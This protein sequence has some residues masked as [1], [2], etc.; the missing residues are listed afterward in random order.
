MPNKLPL[1]TKALFGLGAA[2]AGVKENA[3]GVF[4]IFFYA[5]VVGLSA[6]LAGLAV[7]CALV[8]DAIS[9]PLVGYWSD[10][11]KSKWGRRHPFIYASAIP[12]AFSF[13][14]LFSPPEG[15]SETTTF[16]WMLVFSIAVRFSITFNSIPAVSLVAELAT[17]YSDRNGL[18]SFRI[19]FGWTGSIG[20]SY[21]AYKWL[22]NIME[23]GQ[24]GRFDLGAY[25]TYGLIGALCM[26]ITV[27]VSG[28]GTHHLIPTLQ[29]VKKSNLSLKTFAKAVKFLATSKTFMSLLGAVLI[30]SVSAGVLDVFALYVNTYFWGLSSEQLVTLLSG[31]IVGALIAF[32]GIKIYGAKHD[33]KH[34]LMF[35]IMVAIITGP[36]PI[37]L[38]LLGLLPDNGDP[39]ILYIVIAS[40]LFT[41]FVNVGV[42]IL[43]N[44]MVA[45]IADVHYV[46]S[47]VRQEGLHYSAVTFCAKATTGLG[48]F[49]AGVSLDIISFPT[50]VG[51]NEV[52]APVIEALG[53]ANV[54]LVI[55]FLFTS[56]FMLSKYTLTREQH[57]E[58]IEKIAKMK[59]DNTPDNK[60][61]IQ[62]EIIDRGEAVPSS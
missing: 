37:I 28:L 61:N 27:I 23:N 9:D 57:S 53:I 2:A 44:S 60:P 18:M 8:F 26:M 22:F 42:V 43:S 11:F 56:L 3:F 48:G 49:I 25:Q 45:D 47:G 16:L 38:R 15:M 6:S 35:C 34:M 36:G 46:K 4:L 59:R 5:Q 13:F 19:F 1:K 20:L 55:V 52:E 54:L 58:A 21:V 31:S 14:C 12:L 24:D 30:A 39:L 50:G 40:T 10:N 29:S 17:D 33:K 32:T 7:L 62:N 51:M 41:V